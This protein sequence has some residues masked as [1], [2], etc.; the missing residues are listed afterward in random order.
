MCDFEHV[1]SLQKVW[2]GMMVFTETRCS[3]DHAEEHDH[4]FSRKREFQVLLS[5]KQK[6]NMT[7]IMYFQL[8]FTQIVLLI[9]EDEDVKNFED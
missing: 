1:N 4:Q 6:I 5:F 2:Y 7:F 9:T 3:L 8:N